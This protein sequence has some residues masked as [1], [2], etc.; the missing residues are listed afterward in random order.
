MKKILISILILLMVGITGCNDKGFDFPDTI[1]QMCEDAKNAAKDC[2]Q[3]YS[4][5]SLE[6]KKGCIV[7][8]KPGEKKYPGGWAWYMPQFD[9]WVAGLTGYK[10]GKVWI[11]IGCNPNNGGEVSYDYLKHEFGH[12]WLLTNFKTSSHSPTYKNCFRNWNDV[13][14]REVSVKVAKKY[15]NEEGSTILH[16]D[17]IEED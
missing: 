2:I 13:R 3:Q 5:K 7:E 9:L 12:Y 6:T 14:V 10:D 1:T 11:Q 16:I 8:L 17:F 15:V 4:G